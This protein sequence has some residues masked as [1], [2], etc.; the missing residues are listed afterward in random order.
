MEASQISNNGYIHRLLEPTFK[1]D[2]QVKVISFQEKVEGK[3]L[4]K[5]EDFLR[6]EI[7]LL[8]QI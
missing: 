3:S 7:L 4:K 2:T 6:S 5:L 8:C 1:K